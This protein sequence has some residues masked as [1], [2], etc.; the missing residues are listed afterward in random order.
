MRYANRPYRGNRLLGMHKNLSQFAVLILFLMYWSFAY[1][2]EQINY[3]PQPFTYVTNVLTLFG[4]VFAPFVRLVEVIAP[5]FSWR[6]LRHLIPPLIGWF[7]ARRAILGMLQSFYDLPDSNAAS[8]LLYRLSLT[9]IGFVRPTVIT[10]QNFE[11][12]RQTNPMIKIGGPGR[13]VVF[14]DAALVTELNGRFHRVLGPG[15]H[16]L[17]RFE[18]PRTIVD[19]RPQEREA[20]NIK[21]MTSDGIELTTSLTVTFEILRGE[22][23]PSK[24]NPF[25]YD[26]EAVRTAAYTETVQPDGNIGRWQSLPVLIA[27]GQLR[28]IVAA[29]GLDDLIVSEANG[30]DVHRRLQMEMERRARNIMRN[31]G[32]MIRGTRLGALELDEEVEK[33]RKKYWQAHWNTQQTLQK[34]DGEVE[35]LESHEF[36]RAEAEATMLTAIA[37]GLQRAQRAGRDVTSREVV[38]LR[39]IESL[40][41]MAKNSGRELDLPNQL[42]SQLESIRQQLT[43]ISGK[44]G[45]AEKQE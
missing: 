25:P 7:L 24:T 2:L 4:P 33:V 11:E 32:V 40:E 12:L 3:V 27:S 21:M 15:R 41:A 19:L 18:F 29:D 28:A 22:Q 17:A 16:E 36:A 14:R 5:Y 37:E 26:E 44:T 23:K 13:I 10:L 6:V 8:A 39:L 34:A 20:E 9:R 43:L 42:I 45:E 38:A 35:I 31:F 30:I 1:Q